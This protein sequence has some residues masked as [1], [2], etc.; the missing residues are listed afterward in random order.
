VVIL[1]R[2]Y[3]PGDI[4]TLKIIRDND[5]VDIEIELGIRPSI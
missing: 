1:E 5:V 2:G 4:V 3:R